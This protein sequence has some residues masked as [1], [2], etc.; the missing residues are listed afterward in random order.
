MPP[1]DES[2]SNAKVRITF[3]NRE[4]G[5]T[6]ISDIIEVDPSD[7]SE[8]TRVAF[9]YTRKEYSITNTTALMLHPKT[10]FEEVTADGTNTILLIPR[11]STIDT[12]ELVSNRTS[13][14]LNT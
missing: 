6:F 9:K 3:L 11:G 7:P 12:E 14:R 8:V 5:S 1:H 10:C 4:R 13:K 2:S